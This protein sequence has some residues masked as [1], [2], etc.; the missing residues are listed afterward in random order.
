[1]E[2]DNKSKY[3]IGFIF[4]ITE[5]KN[6]AKSIIKNHIRLGARHIEVGFELRIPLS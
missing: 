2:Q 6:N 3:T 5:L 1:M 4:F